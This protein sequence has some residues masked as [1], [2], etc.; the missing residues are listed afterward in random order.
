MCTST[1]GADVLQVILPRDST[2]PR[3]PKLVR[4]RACAGGPA[5]GGSLC[6]QRKILSGKRRSPP[7]RK[8]HFIAEVQSPLENVPHGPWHGAGAAARRALLVTVRN[9][10]TA[11]GG[12]ARGIFSATVSSSSALV[13]SSLRVGQEVK[14]HRQAHTPLRSDIRPW[15]SVRFFLKPMMTSC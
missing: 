2:G 15:A 5:P 3:V 9:A 4:A 6:S 12:T 10:A 13:L 8:L 11:Q 14:R 1:S 7:E